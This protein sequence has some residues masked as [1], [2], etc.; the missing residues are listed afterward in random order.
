MIR[1]SLFFL[2]IILG[3]QQDWS[4]DNQENFISQCLEENKILGYDSLEYREFCNC[5]LNNIVKIELSYSEFLFRDL[6]TNELE[7]IKENRTHELYYTLGLSYH[8]IGNLKLAKKYYLT[9]IDLYSDQ[10]IN[11]PELA[12]KFIN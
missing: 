8:L 12:L 3:C 7:S 4:Y 1:T 9:S 5:L 6:D 2:L 10:E 11:Y